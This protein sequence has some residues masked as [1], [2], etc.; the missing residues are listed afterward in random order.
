MAIGLIEE[1][2]QTPPKSRGAGR[3]RVMLNLKPDGA[4]SVAIAIDIL[5]AIG[6][7]VDLSG[8]EI[9]RT[10]FEFQRYDQPFPIVSQIYTK[11][12]AD[13]PT[14][15]EK[16][17]LM[18]ISAPGAIDYRNGAI[19]LN[20]FHEWINVPLVGQVQKEI[21]K[22]VILENNCKVAALGELHETKQQANEEAKSIIYLYLRIIPYSTILDPIA[23]GGGIVLGDKLWHGATNYA[24]EISASVN[25]VYREI[26]SS[27][28]EKRPD[29]RNNAL[30][31]LLELA[32]GKDEDAR[33]AISQF[34]RALGNILGVIATFLDVNKVVLDVSPVDYSEDFFELT[35][36]AFKTHFRPLNNH[37]V[38]F[39]AP[40]S[41]DESQ[42]NGLISLSM[43]ALFVSDGFTVSPLVEMR[44]SAS[45]DENI[46][47]IPS[48]AV[49]G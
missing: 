18:T 10:H 44:E 48:A 28:V 23:V 40:F 35:R 7:I 16:I 3:P 4:Y 49:E 30:T 14:I 19:E 34:A 43:Q 26:I 45:S 20:M 46:V 9:C 15:K 6:I 22:P 12:L 21:G 29:L 8:R 33:E 41:Q 42:L 25:Q 13:H 11:L 17:A 38:D 36:T 24:G 2:D 31:G 37:Q 5:H 27:L 47:E 1:L 39:R 32:D